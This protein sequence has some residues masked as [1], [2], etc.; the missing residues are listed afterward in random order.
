MAKIP[1]GHDTEIAGIVIKKEKLLQNLR[2]VIVLFK[3][4][5]TM[6][7]YSEYHNVVTDNVVKLPNSISFE[8]A[9]SCFTKRLTVYY[10]FF[11]IFS[12][13]KVK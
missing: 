6:G 12:I 2:F 9:A 8:Q 3:R 4:Q 10:L 7:V 13:K 5:A 11:M 1:S